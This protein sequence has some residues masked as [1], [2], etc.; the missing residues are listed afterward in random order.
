MLTPF[1]LLAFYCLAI[2]LAGFYLVWSDARRAAIG[3][4]RV[5]ER[6]LLITSFMGGWLAALIARALTHH[7]RRELTFALRFNCIP[8]L[9]ALI[10]LAAIPSARQ[11]VVLLLAG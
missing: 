2:N 6:D 7:R 1:H 8:L 9:W 3:Q 10:C 11:S 5:P 4:Q